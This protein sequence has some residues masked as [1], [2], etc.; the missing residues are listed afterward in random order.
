MTGYVRRK[1]AVFTGSLSSHYLMGIALGAAQYANQHDWHC[2]TF[3]GGPLDDPFESSGVRARLFD[4]VQ[5]DSFDGLIVAAGSLMR[6]VD[7]A[8]VR[9]FLAR[10]GPLP[11]V[12]IGRP[13]EGNIQV[14]LDNHSGIWQIVDHLVVQHGLRRIAFAGGPKNHRASDEKLAAY[15]DALA[16]HGIEFDPEWVVHGDLTRNAA[17]FAPFFE[18]HQSQVQ[19]V[20]AATDL[21]AFGIIEFLQARGVQVPQQVAVTGCSGLAEGLFI[22]P[23]LSTVQEPAFELG[24]SAA[25]ALIEKADG[26]SPPAD[27]VVPGKMIVRNSCGCD[28]LDSAHESGT[29]EEIAGFG[30][31]RDLQELSEN[32]GSLADSGELGRFKSALAL[33]EEA[34]DISRLLLCLREILDRRIAHE[35]G[36]IWLGLL[37]ALLRKAYA[38][39]SRPGASSALREISRRLS[40]VIHLDVS[41]VVSYRQL[42]SDRQIKTLREL[43]AVFN[44]NFDR[45]SISRQ[46][47]SLAVKE[48]HASVFERAN[49]TNDPVQ[50]VFSLHKGVLH[51]VSDPSFRYPASQLLPFDFARFETPASLIVMPLWCRDNLLGLMAMDLDERKGAL[52]ENLQSMLSGALQN[53]SQL[54]DLRAAEQKFSDIA[55]S[56]SDWLWECD[57]DGIYTYCSDGVAKVLGYRAQEVIGKSLFDFLLPTEGVYQAHIRDELFPK[58]APLEQLESINRHRDG[59]EITLLISGKPIWQGPYFVGYRGAF[60]DVTELKVQENRIRQLAYSDT[61]TGL[62][63]RALFNDRLEQT[64]ANA[65]R[66]HQRFALFFLDLDRFKQIN[67]TLGHDAG[68]LLLKTVAERLRTCV[69]EVDTLARLGGDEFTVI[70][71]NIQ[72]QES[73]EMV[74]RRIVAAMAQPIEL[75]GQSLVASSSI[76]I[77]LYPRD[78]KSTQALLRCADKAMYKSKEHG[79]NRYSFFDNGLDEKSQRRMLL[80]VGMRQALQDD[81]F[82]LHYQPQIDAQTGRV[83]A[84]EA[85]IRWHTEEL[86]HVSPVEFIALAEE[87]GLIDKIGLWVFASACEQASAWWAEGVEVRVAINVSARQLKNPLLAEQ[88]LD[89]V[90]HYAV[91]AHWL[92]IEITET[93]MVD[94]EATARATLQTLSNFGL[95]IALDDFGTGFASLSSLKKFPVNT[96]KIDRSF[97]SDCLTQPD[98]ASIVTAIVHMARSLRLHTVAEGVETAEQES[99]L[100]AVGCEVLQGY[101]FS[102]PTPVEPLT[103]WLKTHAQS[104]RLSQAPLAVEMLGGE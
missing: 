89:I 21:Q 23:A 22:Q 79:R 13:T 102:R 78:G 86:G 84:V 103:A 52:Y 25:R 8:R 34:E 28:V 63:N 90:R 72:N 31:L 30:L 19:A 67:D 47:A 51:D 94:N 70:L 37:V 11:M 17:W 55:H 4:V 71:S 42:E 53:E 91:Q 16:H 97:I 38:Y 80:E 69:R 6:Y 56:T 10:F 81:G 95:S 83:V 58:R 75:N 60:K 35:D 98:S 5:P 20:V 104:T 46:L 36:V 18:A 41:K 74:A 7:E 32:T 50:S 64:L 1:L 88:L 85:L 62:A 45:Q 101:Y 40:A 12:S 82:V 59:F 26:A 73:A 39:Q 76:G 27:I 15:R 24:W 48:C 43:N 65:K 96:V 68:D 49:H 61:L 44:A 2:V 57:P 54:K 92:E 77:A 100:K 3:A 66:A 33:G 9:S 14:R 29:A 99:F 87:V 93:A